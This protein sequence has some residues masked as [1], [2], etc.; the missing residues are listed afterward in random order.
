M[1]N[2][3]PDHVWH[4]ARPYGLLPTKSER[5]DGTDDTT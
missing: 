2:M 5:K 1:K 3:I 4:I